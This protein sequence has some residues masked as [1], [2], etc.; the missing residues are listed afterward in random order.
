MNSK[1]KALGLHR[2]KLSNPFRATERRIVQ[3]ARTP[4]P[5]TLLG[6]R[7][8]WWYMQELFKAGRSIEYSTQELSP[9]YLRE[10]VL[11]AFGQDLARTGRARSNR[12]FFENAP[13]NL[14]MRI[15]A[16]SEALAPSENKK[17]DSWKWPH[18][19]YAPTHVMGV[20]CRTPCIFCE[21]LGPPTPK[22]PVNTPQGWKW[23]D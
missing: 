20:P 12:L 3:N 19:H 7:M 5:S 13:N 2:P 11:A 17:R 16:G 15:L 6:S 1:L 4:G 22:K 18:E 23:K 21:A 8:S 14:E 9:D 10:K